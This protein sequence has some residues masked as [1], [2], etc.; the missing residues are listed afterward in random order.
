MD[1]GELRF[2]LGEEGNFDF[3]NRIIVEGFFVKFLLV[4][5]IVMFIVY[6]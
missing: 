5:D 3:V 1:V 2:Y 6:V 4:W